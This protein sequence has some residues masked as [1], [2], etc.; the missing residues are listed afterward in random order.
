MRSCIKMSMTEIDMHNLLR[1]K[2]EK[3]KMK[4]YLN[5]YGQYFGFHH[6]EQRNNN[7]ILCTALITKSAK[8]KKSGKTGENWQNSNKDLELNSN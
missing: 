7:N 8:M 4:L 1:R 2:G 6:P 3:S 5:F